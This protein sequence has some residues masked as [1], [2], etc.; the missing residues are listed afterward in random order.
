MRQRHKDT[1]AI[2]VAL[3]V[4]MAVG[5]G[6]W[7]HYNAPC[8]SFVFAHQKASELPARCVTFYKH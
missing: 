7:A 8:D 4:L 5:V 3:L 6:I 2:V 1:A